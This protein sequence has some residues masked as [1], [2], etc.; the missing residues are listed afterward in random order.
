MYTT[1]CPM[2]NKPEAD[3]SEE[4]EL[5]CDIA[6]R[7]LPLSQKQAVWESQRIKSYFGRA[8]EERRKEALRGEED[9][10]RVQSS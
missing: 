5:I 6:F 8:R 2:C 4:R 9:R 3:H 10:S 7:E 1:I